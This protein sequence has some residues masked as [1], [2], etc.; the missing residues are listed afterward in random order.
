MERKQERTKDSRVR[1]RDDSQ[2]LF[3]PQSYCRGF[4]VWKL[5]QVLRFKALRCSK[6][7]TWRNW[8][9]TQHVK[10]LF[11]LVFPLSNIRFTDEKQNS[12]SD[13][14]SSNLIKQN[15]EN[16]LMPSRVKGSMEREF[17]GNW[18][19][20]FTMFTLQVGKC[21]DRKRIFYLI[22]R[23]KAQNFLYLNFSHL[24]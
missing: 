19:V 9:T 16:C 21:L 8:R 11:F 10:A 3:I 2:F 1:F 17:Q 24:S 4:V 7:F 13:R 12:K 6:D 22:F 23:R 14:K 20:N 18:S 5:G 15:E